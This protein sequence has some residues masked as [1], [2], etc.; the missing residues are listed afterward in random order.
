L[1][2]TVAVT[3]TLDLQHSDAASLDHQISGAVAEVGRVLWRE[4]VER[5][6][7]VVETGQRPP[8]SACGGR[9]KSNGRRSRVEQT[10]VGEVSFERERWRCTNC[11]QEMAPLDQALGLAAR[12]GHTLDVQERCLWLATEMSFAKASQAASEL[13]GWQVSHGR[14]HE[15]AQEVGADLE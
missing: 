9:F 5:L 11:G 4:V 13:R 15:W 1:Q 3:V 12:T 14:I 7:Q 10:L 8:C 2:S 6:R